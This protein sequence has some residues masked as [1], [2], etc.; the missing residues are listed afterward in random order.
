MI[1]NILC[2]A[3]KTLHVALSFCLDEHNKVSLRDFS[4]QEILRITAN[5]EIW[6]IP[7]EILRSYCYCKIALKV[8]AVFAK[9]KNKTN[10]SLV[11]YVESFD[12]SK[13]NIKKIL[14]QFQCLEILFRKSVFLLFYISLGFKSSF[15]CFTILDIKIWR[16]KSTLV[17]MKPWVWFGNLGFTFLKSQV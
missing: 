5:F 6:N 2:L 13:A 11:K 4:G 9:K 7:W 3:G 1:N 14:L 16:K 17:F 15:N 10:T 12:D 8:Y